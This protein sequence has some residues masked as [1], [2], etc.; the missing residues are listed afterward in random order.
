MLLLAG[1]CFLVSAAVVPGCAL[2]PTITLKPNS[3]TL[4]IGVGNLSVTGS[5]PQWGDGSDVT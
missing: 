4:K 2:V 1:L 5:A 3:D